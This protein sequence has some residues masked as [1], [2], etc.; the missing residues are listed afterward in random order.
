MN[1]YK[2]IKVNRLFGNQHEFS[3]EHRA[4]NAL[5]FFS[6]ITLFLASVINAAFGYT[7]LALWTSVFTAIGLYLFIL[8]RVKRKYSIASFIFALFS[9]SFLI[10]LYYLNSGISGP[11]GYAFVLSFLLLLV[12]T[13]PRWHVLWLGCHLLLVP[14]LFFSELHLSEYITYNYNSQA[15]MLLDNGYTFMIV[16]IFVFFIGKYIRSSYVAE[17]KSAKKTAV[18]LERKIKELDFSNKEKDR[19][20]S[21]IAHDL[22]SPLNSISSYLEVLA[23]LDMTAEER[24][25][26][27]NQLLEH[28]R[29]TSDLLNNLLNWSVKKTLKAEELK[30]VK[31]R[32]HCDAVVNLM[33][34]DA[35]KKKIDIHCDLDACDHIVLGESEMVYLIIRNLVNNGIKFTHENGSVNIAAKA[36]KDKI[37]ICISDT[38]VGI[39]A[40]K[41]S[42][43]FQTKIK[44]TVGTNRENGVGLGLVLCQDFAEAMGGSI[45][46]SSEENVG[47]EFVVTLNKH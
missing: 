23:E 43:F 17:K 27:N 41:Q 18:L 11:T 34:H 28:T 3:M 10:I 47:S 42:N 2:K 45:H 20:F 36:K 12:V 7:E 32:N 16:I 33:R 1:V 38:G 9:Y 39:P 8:S 13:K 24:D 4:L 19:L 31:L 46:F 26:I 29:N 37:Q 15:E 5:C 35:E 44:P 21:I 22:R 40:E 6:S 14:F 30:P 25:M